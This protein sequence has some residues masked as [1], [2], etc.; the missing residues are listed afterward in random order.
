M[1]ARRRSAPR[2]LRRRARRATARPRSRA[3]RDGE[4]D[5]I[6]LDVMLPK[7][8]GFDVCRE[9]RRAGVD[10]DDPAAD[11]A[12]RR[13]R[14]GARPRP[15]RRRLRDQA[16]QPEGAAGADPRAAAARRVGAGEPAISAIRRLRARFGPRRAAAR[17]EGRSPRRRSSSSC[18]TCLRAAPGAS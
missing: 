3:A 11:G 12:H 15:R 1:R 18:S 14:Q 7:K 6:L 16:V 17:R 13:D 2:G 10:V 9:L 4:F 5:L 8:D